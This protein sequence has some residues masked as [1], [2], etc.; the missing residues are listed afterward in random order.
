[1]TAPASA[2]ASRQQVIPAWSSAAD[3]R[4]PGDTN[5]FGMTEPVAATTFGIETNLS[6]ASG[7][8]TA[9]TASSSFS[10]RQLVSVPFAPMPPPCPATP[11]A[12]I[13]RPNSVEFHIVDSTVTADLNG[14][15]WR[16]HCHQGRGL[17]RHPRRP[18]RPIDTPTA[19]PADILDG[20]LTSPD[21]SL[22]SIDTRYVLKAT[23]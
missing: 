6:S 3:I 17:G 11:S 13:A 16:R 12:A 21:I 18:G 22:A 2:A 23:P 15:S 9:F 7:S 14:R 20:S 5:V 4:A 10:D 8:T 1:V 19:P